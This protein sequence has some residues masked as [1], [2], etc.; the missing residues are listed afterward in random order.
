M[1]ENLDIIVR[2]ATFTQIGNVVT[3]FG[4]LLVKH[5]GP[6]AF[7]TITL[8]LPVPTTSAI[9]SGTGQLDQDNEYVI[10]YKS[11]VGAK[12]TLQSNAFGL[13]NQ[14]L[15]YSYQYFVS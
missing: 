12:I 8:S 1:S 13:F 10:V 15:Q 14:L 3:V 9:L 6:N 4:S 11:G 5:T 2:S 7:A